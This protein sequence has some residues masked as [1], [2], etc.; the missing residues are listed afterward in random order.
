MPIPLT[1]RR[2]LFLIGSVL[3]LLG[4]RPLAASDA[5]LGEKAFW[6]RCSACH[7]ATEDRNKIGPSLKGVYGRRIGS[8]PD[9]DYSDAMREMGQ[10]GA[11]WDDASLALYL[12]DPRA[13]VAGNKMSF[14]G[15]ADPDEVARIIAYLRERAADPDA[16]GR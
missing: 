10:A 13:F 4:T 6:A 14:Q 15:I 5:E 12:A 9:F 7:S 11:R 8:L 16:P 2:L 3:T 1:R